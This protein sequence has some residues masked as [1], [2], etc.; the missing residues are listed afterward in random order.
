ML[1]LLEPSLTYKGEDAMNFIKGKNNGID[2]L[3]EYLQDPT[4]MLED[5]SRRLVL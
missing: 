1:K 2:L 4:T 5:I 3:H